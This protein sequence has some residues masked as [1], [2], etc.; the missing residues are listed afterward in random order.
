MKRIIE[1]ANQWEIN[2]VITQDEANLI[3]E[4]LEPY[5]EH[6]FQQI[7]ELTEADPE[8]ALSKLV[9]MTNF[10]S[11]AGNKVPGIVTKLQKAIRKFQILAHKLGTKLGAESVTISVGFPSG[12]TVS[13]TWKI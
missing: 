9:K 11:A 2:G 8:A 12:V 13:L 7:Y 1:L 6:E 4:L 5:L 3:Y 10:L